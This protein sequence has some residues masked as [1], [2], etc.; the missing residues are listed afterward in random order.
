[1]SPKVAA[2]GSPIIPPCRPGWSA[3]RASRTI[4]RWTPDS[5]RIVV[6]RV[7]EEDRG[8][9]Y[10][11]HDDSADDQQDLPGR[12]AAPPAIFRRA[13]PVL[14]EILSRQRE[15]QRPVRAKAIFH[16]LPDPQPEGAIPGEAVH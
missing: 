3:S 11:H 1:M 5:V 7:D 15:G 10:P 4:C 8:D 14:A 9:P 6:D 2:S 12:Q 16:P 13:E